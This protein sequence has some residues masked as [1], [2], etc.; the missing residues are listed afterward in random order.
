MIK[1]IIGKFCECLNK[2]FRALQDQLIIYIDR[3]ELFDT[4]NKILSSVHRDHPEALRISIPAGVGV[5][6]S[7]PLRLRKAERV[8]CGGA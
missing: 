3:R 8:W 6:M 1:S 4:R 7:V 5:S 2:N